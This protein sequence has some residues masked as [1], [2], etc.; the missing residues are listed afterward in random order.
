LEEEEEAEEEDAAD[1]AEEED[2]ADEAEDAAED[3]ADEAEDAAEDAADEAEDA[4]DEAEDAAD[5]AEDAAED[6]N[7]TVS[8]TDDESVIVTVAAAEDAADEAAAESQDNG[9]LTRV[10]GLSDE[11]DIPAIE[12]E[13]IAESGTKPMLEP[14]QAVLQEE[15]KEKEKIEE[16]DDGS[17][18]SD[19]TDNDIISF[20]SNNDDNK[21]KLKNSKCQSDRACFNEEINEDIENAEVKLPFDIALPFLTKFFTYLLR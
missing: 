19:T 6:E 21:E 8:V 11:E 7:E 15:V 1:E 5:E 3:A 18:N 13:P 12:N 10:T 20:S 16:L 14:E 2:A 9:R 17:R 4:A